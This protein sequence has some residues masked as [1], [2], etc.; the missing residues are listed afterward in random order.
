MQL[1]IAWAGFKSRW[2]TLGMFLLHHLAFLTQ[3]LSSL[4]SLL[5][6]LH[7]TTQTHSFRIRIKCVPVR[8]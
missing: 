7:V 1:Y 4:P 6:S 5:P 2:I 3:S 8:I